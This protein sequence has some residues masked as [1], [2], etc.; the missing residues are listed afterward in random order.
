MS[1]NQLMSNN[2]VNIMFLYRDR[3][4]NNRHNNNKMSNNSVCWYW[5]R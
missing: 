4:S 5:V 3:N 2:R 1:W